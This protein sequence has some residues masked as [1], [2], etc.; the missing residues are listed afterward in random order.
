MEKLFSRRN[1]LKV[2]PFFSLLILLLSIAISISLYF[3]YDF[4][5]QYLSE[6]GVGPTSIIFNS[7]LIISALLL[8]PFF[9]SS[10]LH[11][12][13]LKQTG[14]ILGIA[15]MISLAGIGIFP[16][17][18][19]PHHLITAF[20]FFFA[21]ALA[22][23]FFSVDYFVEALKRATAKVSAVK[24]AKRS[25]YFFIG[26]GVFGLAVAAYAFCFLFLFMEPLPQKICVSAIMIWV[27]IKAFVELKR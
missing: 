10:L 19:Y 14:S 15:A 2:L 9:F 11:K 21:S 1:V 4:F 3:K 8:I 26:F 25:K 20:M 24:G 13:F 23:I 6:L 22:I 17:P 27:F 7:G 12:S 18:N 16:I 5:N